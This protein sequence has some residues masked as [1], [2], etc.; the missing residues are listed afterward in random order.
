MKPVK[1]LFAP[2]IL[3]I[4]LIIGLIVQQRAQEKLRAENESLA[5]QIVQLRTDNESLSNLVVQAK[6]SQS[7]PKEQFNELLKLR[8]EVGVLRNQAGQLGKIRA[9]NQ[10]LH[11]QISTTQNRS[12]FPSASQSEWHQTNTI[13]AARLIGLGLIMYA[14]DNNNQFPTN[15]NQIAN[16][17]VG[18]T[19]QT[20]GIGTDA[21]ELVNPVSQVAASAIILREQV[22]FQTTD[23][24]WSRTYVFADGHAEVQI[25]ADGN[26]DGYEKQHLV[27]PP[28]Q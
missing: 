5:Q 10:Q 18:I 4:A 6:S 16:L 13:N 3:I 28:N 17:L 21:F 8:G 23:G 7:M 22:P 26:F 20:S 1:I 19:N 27:P 14:G 24:K 9:E 2:V 12:Q 25:S 15:F 11:E